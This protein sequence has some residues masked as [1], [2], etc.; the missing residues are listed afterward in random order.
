M[1]TFELLTGHSLFDPEGGQTRSVE[2][3]HLAKMM[4]VTGETFSK[5]LL[6]VSRESNKY[7]DKE[8]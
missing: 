3:D 6:T 4:E 2:D 5:A 7:F 8:G 1:Q